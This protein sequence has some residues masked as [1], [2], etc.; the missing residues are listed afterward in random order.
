MKRRLM[1]MLAGALVVGGCCANMSNHEIVKEEQQAMQEAHK[2]KLTYFEGA[3]VRGPKDEKVMSFVF[4]GGSFGEGMP[5]ILETLK[6]HGIKGAFFFTGDFLENESFKPYVKE[7]YEAGH[8]VGPHSY[9]HP[10][11]CDWGDRSKTL[12]SRADFE[13]DFEKN[14]RLIEDEYGI[15]RGELKWWIPPYEHYNTEV[16]GWA[17]ALGYPMFNLTNGTLTHA[18]YTEATAKNYRDSETI[19]NSVFEYEAKHEDGLNGW[20]MLIHAG[21]GDGRPDKFFL[22]FD[23]LINELKTR[24]YSFVRADEL[25]E[26]T[27]K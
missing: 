22:K 3:V 13:A 9:G 20:V 21:A 18:D 26:G 10:L 8:Y 12:I 24:G 25:I 15:G 4:T 27:Y 11:Y 16:A 2:A 17:T 6:K 23:A 14:L 1:L 5:Y 19:W 7:A